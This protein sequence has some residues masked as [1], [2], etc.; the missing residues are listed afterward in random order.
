M[1]IIVRSRAF[2]SRKHTNKQ[3]NNKQQQQPKSLRPNHCQL[4]PRSRTRPPLSREENHILSENALRHRLTAFERALR[5]PPLFILHSCL[6]GGGPPP[7]PTFLHILSP[8]R[9]DISGCECDSL[10]IY[11]YLYISLPFLFFVWLSLYTRTR[12]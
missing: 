3:T 8:L 7:P 9:R 6:A 4:S 12:V 1:V 2:F 11:I 10:Y 5:R